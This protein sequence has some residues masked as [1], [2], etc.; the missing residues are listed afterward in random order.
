MRTSFRQMAVV[1]MFVAVTAMS[2]SRSMG[3]Q[4]A[5]SMK[6]TPR[7]IKWNGDLM[8]ILFHMSQAFET[9]IGLEVDPQQPKTDVGFYLEKAMLPDVLNAIVQS[10]P[11]YQWRERDGFIE[12]FPLAGRNPLLDTM[13]TSFRV[14]DVVQQEA[15]NRLLSLPE[16]QAAMKAMNL[17]HRAP[18][19]AA[20]DEKAAKLSLSLQG[21]TIRQALNQIVQA[22]GGRFWM[23]RMEGAGSFSIAGSPWQP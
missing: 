18:T 6:E 7:V 20:K 8:F 1:A 3:Q 16:A 14:A 2:G 23:F 22:N 5:P 12:V 19:N 4:A 11:S 9:T 10:A 21:V 17:N 13:I 15:I